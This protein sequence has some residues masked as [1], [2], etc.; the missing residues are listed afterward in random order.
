[1]GMPWRSARL[2]MTGM[3]KPRPFQVT[4]VGFFESS[5][6]AKSASMS[7]SPLFSP[8]TPSRFGT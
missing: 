8:T 4:T 5:H 1:M 3:S 2:V 6:C 7:P